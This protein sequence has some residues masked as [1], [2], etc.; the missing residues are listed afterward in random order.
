MK[1]TTK[2]WKV[3]VTIVSTDVTGNSSGSEKKRTKYFDDFE[4]A[5]CFARTGDVEYCDHWA[6]VTKA[7]IFEYEIAS[8]RKLELKK[9][10]VITDVKKTTWCWE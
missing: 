4:N 5:E 10:E 7:E 1:E 3:T 2:L 9:H 6:H 8:V